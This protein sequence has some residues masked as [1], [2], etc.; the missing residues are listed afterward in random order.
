[1]L[2]LG[3]F[4][5]AAWSA[6][7]PSSEQ[8]KA[9][10]R[11][12]GAENPG[13]VAAARKA[14]LAIPDLD[15]VL[16]DALNSGNSHD[17]V[18]AYHVIDLLRRETLFPEVLKRSLKENESAVFFALCALKDHDREQKIADALRTRVSSADEQLTA[19]AKVSI[20]SC[21]GRIGPELVP[22]ELSPLLADPNDE[23]RIAATSLVGQYRVERKEAAYEDQLIS[24]LS[25]KPYQLRLEALGWIEKTGPDAAIRQKLS[26]CLQDENSEVRSLCKELSRP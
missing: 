22:A 14:L 21:F 6:S 17:R 19:G 18:S 7:P 24:A 25:K 3:G 23:V 12:L 8:W 20:L 9:Y 16:K 13:Q 4:S 11:Q 5:W 2:V 15:G 10:A 26:P 1:M